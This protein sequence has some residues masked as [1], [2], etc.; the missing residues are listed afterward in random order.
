LLLFDKKW[1][2]R[3]EIGPLS[4]SQSG[5]LGGGGF[6][7]LTQGGARPELVFLVHP[8]LENNRSFAAIVAIIFSAYTYLKASK[9]KACLI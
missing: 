2:Q 8:L 3:R 1:N 6:F 9:L 7:I 5:F 4:A